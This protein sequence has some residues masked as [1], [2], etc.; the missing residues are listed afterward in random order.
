M[1]NIDLPLLETIESYQQFLLSVIDKVKEYNLN[2][3]VFQV[4]P[5]NDA[6]YQSD[7]NPWSEFI[8]GKQGAYPGFDVFGWFVE[9]ATEAGVEVHAWLNPY[10]V[11]NR[12][13]ADLEMSKKEFLNTL[14][15]NNFARLRPDLVIETVQSKLILD[16]SSEEVREF[17]SESALKSPGNTT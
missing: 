8:T 10:R 17:V 11:T 4:R 15:E 13:L 3:I 2:T 6:L 5:C 9:K 14:A 7:L 12:K 16:P 1:A